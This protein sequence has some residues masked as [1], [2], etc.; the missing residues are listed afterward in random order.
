[1]KKN[2]FKYLLAG[3]AISF[4]ISSCT[5]M[6]KDCNGVKHYKTKNGIYI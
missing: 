2:Y 5:S 3:L 6:K 4:M 1:M